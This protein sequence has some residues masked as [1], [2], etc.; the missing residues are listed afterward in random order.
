MPKLL[1]PLLLL[2]ATS[3]LL[4]ARLYLLARE[5]KAQPRPVPVRGSDRQP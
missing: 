4:L 2:T 3:A 5:Q 1:A